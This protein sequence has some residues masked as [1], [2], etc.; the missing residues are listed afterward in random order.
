MAP[1]AGGIRLTVS[2]D[3]VGF[4]VPARSTKGLGIVGMQERV[5]L[6]GGRFELAADLRQLFGHRL[7]G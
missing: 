5:R 3:G 6:T 1:A 7:V 4:A 2:D